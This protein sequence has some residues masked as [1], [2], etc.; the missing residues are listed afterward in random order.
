MVQ[1][2][3]MFD[4]VMRRSGEQFRLNQ[5]QRRQLLDDQKEDILRED[6]RHQREQE[7][8]IRVQR[9]R[10]A[11]LRAEREEVA[12]RQ[13]E[14]EEAARRQRE[15]EQR[16]NEE[17]FQ[18]H[19]A[20]RSADDADDRKLQ[21]DLRQ[22]VGLRGFVPRLGIKALLGPRHHNRWNQHRVVYSNHVAAEDVASIRPDYDTEDVMRQQMG[23]NTGSCTC[24]IN[25]RLA[26]LSN[27]CVVMVMMLCEAKRLVCRTLGEYENYFSNVVRPAI[28]D[29]VQIV[30]RLRAE[31]LLCDKCPDSPILY[32]GP[33]GVDRARIPFWLQNTEKSR[34]RYHPRLTP[35]DR[36][37]PRWIEET[38]LTEMTAQRREESS[39]RER[40]RVVS[41]KPGDDLARSGFRSYAD[42]TINNRDV[43]D[44]QGSFT[45]HQSLIDLTADTIHE[46]L[47]VMDNPRRTLRTTNNVRQVDETRGYM[48]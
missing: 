20:Q 45:R 39:H 2:R 18:A 10:E 5:Q 11:Q 40:R 17:K 16:E 28:R 46:P 1:Q 43:G 21:C 31:Q 36:V 25:A 15:R 26:S 34:T 9:E 33:S 42:A 48:Y 24:S 41:F 29:D 44:D 19:H 22:H 38:S 27:E 4:A 12:R 30:M 23:N 14:R 47:P 3:D 13:R 6:R 7:D 8:L 35:D 37:E 32:F